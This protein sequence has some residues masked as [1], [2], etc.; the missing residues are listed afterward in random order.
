VAGSVAVGTDDGT[1]AAARFDTPLGIAI[2]NDGNILVADTGNHS[3]RKVTP[4]G[5]VTTLAGYGSSG[6]K[7]A[8][9]A[10]AK[11]NSPMG[12]TVG[13]DG[14]IYIADNGNY[15]VRLLKMIWI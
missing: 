3:I 7:N 10:N 12:I 5:V 14:T 15:L 6:L 4:S 11:F 2:D 1:G 13:P 9:G 8:V